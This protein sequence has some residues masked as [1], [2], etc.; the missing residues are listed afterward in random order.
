VIRAHPFPDQ[1]IGEDILH[2]REVRETGYGLVY[3]PA[4]EVRHLN[5]RGWGELFSYN[6][7]LGRSAVATHATTG[8]W[9]L[10]IFRRL[11]MLSFV[12]PLIILPTITW[13]LSRSRWSYLARFL[14]IMP[15]CLVGNVVWATA[16]RR[17]LLEDRR[18]HPSPERPAA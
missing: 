8:C 17:E 7:R 15:M 6:R 10:P 1:T 16:Y 5:R 14:A 4:I 2:S 18:R 12:A 13:R 3:A 9:H 11:P